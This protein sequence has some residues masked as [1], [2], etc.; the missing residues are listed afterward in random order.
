MAQ[1]VGVLDGRGDAAGVVVGEQ[2]LGL[3]LQLGPATVVG[4]AVGAA[5]SGG[6]S[7]PGGPA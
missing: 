5:Q 3:G 2:L 7:V 6:Q 4:R 1:V